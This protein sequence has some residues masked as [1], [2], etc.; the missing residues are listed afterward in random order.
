MPAWLDGFVR[1]LKM[2]CEDSCNAIPKVLAE[3]LSIYSREGF[4]TFAQA[5]THAKSALR[6][7][8]P[9]PLASRPDVVRSRRRCAVLSVYP[10]R[11]ISYIPVEGCQP[12]PRSLQG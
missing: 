3:E 1:P 4:M 5:G 8:T 10:I 12:P 6:V 2:R 9:H 11:R 7:T